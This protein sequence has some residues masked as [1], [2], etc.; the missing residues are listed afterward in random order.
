MP[1]QPITQQLDPL[2]SL[3][4][5]MGGLKTST[6]PPVNSNHHNQNSNII[7]P[8]SAQPENNPISDLLRQLGAPQDKPLKV[9]IYLFQNNLFFFYIYVRFIIR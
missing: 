1:S 5:N 9:F 4:Q 7:R 3:V 8:N 2:H 6:P